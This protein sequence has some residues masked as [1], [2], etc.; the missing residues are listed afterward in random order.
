MAL[1]VI[2]FHE[3]L[4]D[5]FANEALVKTPTTSTDT[6]YLATL[7]GSPIESSRFSV[8][9]RLG[10]AQHAVPDTYTLNLLPPN[11]TSIRHIQSL[12]QTTDMLVATYIEADTTPTYERQ[13]D[14]DMNTHPPTRGGIQPPDISQFNTVAQPALSELI[15]FNVLGALVLPRQVAAPIIN[16]MH[17]A[18]TNIQDLRELGKRQRYKAAET[19]NVPRIDEEFLARCAL[20]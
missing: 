4:R 3:E 18:R 2:S 20:R 8:S 5:K 17:D 16:A 15:R 11:A 19:R 13:P 12:V 6:F 14:T 9:A 10:L 1:D 7:D